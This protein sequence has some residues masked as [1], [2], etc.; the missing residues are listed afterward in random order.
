MLGN[1]CEP[2]A[3]L[4]PRGC[5]TLVPHGTDQ[6]IELSNPTA[7]ACE[8]LRREVLEVAPVRPRRE[9]GRRVGPV[10]GKPSFRVLDLRGGEE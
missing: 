4:S 7:T 10:D 1:D 2:L 9:H 8:L 6:K 3:L 5:A